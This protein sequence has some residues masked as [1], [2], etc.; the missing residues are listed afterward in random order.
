MN[1]E[2]ILNST[3][4]IVL[5]IV[6]AVI[7]IALT[8]LRLVATGRSDNL[9]EIS[10]NFLKGILVIVFG[11]KKTPHQPRY[12]APPKPHQ[13]KLGKTFL[14]LKHAG[15][16]DTEYKIDPNHGFSI[17]SAPNNQLQIQDNAVD[18]HHANIYFN[19]KYNKFCIKNLSRKKQ[20]L[21]KDS[22][23]LRPTILG[24]GDKIT[25]GGCTLIF[26]H[27]ID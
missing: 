2:N 1:P 26:R 15:A 13:I 9:S 23:I 24:N 18:K 12:T 17:G 6:L 20:I 22:V 11:S 7:V 4:F 27:L 3:G 14:V 5:I 8:T 16:S 21:V 25:I 10:V 19:I